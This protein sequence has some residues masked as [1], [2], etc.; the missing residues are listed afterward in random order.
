MPGDSGPGRLAVGRSPAQAKAVTGLRVLLLALLLLNAVGITPAFAIPDGDCCGGV[1]CDCGCAAPQVAALP[2]TL[3]RGT[4][5]AALPQ[6]TF[7]AK[8]FSSSRYDAPFRP[9]A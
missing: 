7:V 5:P 2:V 9:P 6:F 8:P 1:S 4:W 3:A